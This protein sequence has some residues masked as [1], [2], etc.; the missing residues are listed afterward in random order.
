MLIPP[1]LFFML[2]MGVRLRRQEE[3]GLGPNNLCSPSPS[4]MQDTRG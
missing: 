3:S 4:S 2:V 1:V